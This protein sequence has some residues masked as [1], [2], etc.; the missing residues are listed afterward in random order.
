M[1]TTT[2]QSPSFTWD[3]VVNAVSYDLIIK[4][5]LTDQ[6]VYSANEGSP[7]H[8]V[9]TIP[10][11]TYN[12]TITANTETDDGSG[13]V[14]SDTVT[15]ETGILIRTVQDLSV[16]LDGLQNEAD[17]V[18]FKNSQVRIRERIKSLTTQAQQLLQAEQNLINFLADK[19]T[20]AQHHINTTNS[21]AGISS[22]L[23]NFRTAL[24]SL[25][26]AGNNLVKLN[27]QF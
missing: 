6:V 19:P 2:S 25:V 8:V 11:G 10:Q 12:Y 13:G 23:D 3:S 5:N 15:V 1:K 17:F 16:T 9:T 26:Q 7:A 14:I 22:E 27:P 24:Q 18:E 21:I 20:I 4:N